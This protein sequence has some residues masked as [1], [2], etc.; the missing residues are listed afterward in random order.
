MLYPIPPGHAYNIVVG[1]NTKLSEMNKEYMQTIYPKD[2]GD[3]TAN[4]LSNQNEEDVTA[5]D[6]GNQDEEDMTAIDNG[7]QDEEDMTAIDNGNQN[8]EDM[9]AIDNSNQNKEDISSY[10]LM[11]PLTGDDNR[12]TIKLN[13]G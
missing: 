1:W 4:N 3:I 11:G 5:I 8:E 12:V 10:P 6:N 9:T 7:N 2:E 13:K